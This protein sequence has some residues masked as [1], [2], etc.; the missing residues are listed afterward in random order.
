MLIAKMRMLHSI[1]CGEIDNYKLSRHVTY[2]RA[3]NAER[4]GNAI[5][6][7]ADAYG[8]GTEVCGTHKECYSDDGIKKL[9][10]EV[11]AVHTEFYSEMQ[12]A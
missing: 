5:G 10:A 2:I 11:C 9:G 7:Y 1:S 4:I 3:W 6:I 8:V 12:P